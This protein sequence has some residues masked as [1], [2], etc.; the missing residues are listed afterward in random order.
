MTLGE[1]FRDEESIW[2][3]ESQHSGGRQAADLCELEASLVYRVAPGQSS[4][5]RETLSR[6]GKKKDFTCLPK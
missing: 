3:T 6:G 1:S 2:E 5:R 4:L